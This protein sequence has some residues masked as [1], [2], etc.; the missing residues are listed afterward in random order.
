M[1]QYWFWR[2]HLSAQR[3][4]MYSRQLLEVS[5][6]DTRAVD[7]LY[8]LLP[9]PSKHHDHGGSQERNRHFG[10]CHPGKLNCKLTTTLGKVRYRQYATRLDAHILVLPLGTLRELNTSISLLFVEELSLLTAAARS[11]CPVAAFG[12]LTVLVDADGVPCGRGA[13]GTG[14]FPPTFGAPGFA[15]TTG[16][17][18]LGLLASGGPGAGGLKPPGAPALPGPFACGMTG[19][20]L[21]AVCA[22]GAGGGGRRPTGGGGGGGA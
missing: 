11:N 16:A 4:R 10:N 14:G 2:R 17:G 8:G 20:G 15:P 5:T 9:F 1:V 13:L 7:L 22:V 12:A 18:G 6:T 21:D 19:A 3:A